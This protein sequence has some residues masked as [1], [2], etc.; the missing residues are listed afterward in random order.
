MSVAWWEYILRRLSLL[1]N[2]RQRHM[3]LQALL[4]T[5][6]YMSKRGR[7]A[8]QL[9]AS[10]G[11]VEVARLLIAEGANV[12][13]R[14]KVINYRSEKSMAYSQVSFIVGRNIIPSGLQTWSCERSRIVDIKTM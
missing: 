6:Y 7:T 3:L 4:I 12:E 8:L 1:S 10:K 5:Y 13:A 11:H 2:F 9:A 14:N